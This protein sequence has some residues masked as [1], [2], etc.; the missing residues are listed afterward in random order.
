MLEHA[1]GGDGVEWFVA[2]VPVVLHPDLDLRAEPGFGHPVV[3]EG[4]LL[5]AQGHTDDL[6]AIVTSG[7]ERHGAPAAA[8]VENARLGPFMEPE[9][10]AHMVELGLLRFL[11]CA[12]GGLEPSARIG[13]GGTEHQA[14]EGIADVV[15]M[16][17]DF[18]IPM[19]GVSSTMGGSLFGRRRERRTYDTESARRGPRQEGEAGDR[20]GA[21]VGRGRLVQACEDLMD[22][23]LELKVSHHEGPG[24]PQLSGGPQDPTH[25]VG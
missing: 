4:C 14:I 9:L 5:S 2:D 23:A 20:S 15:V 22:I 3:S 7:M 16:A 12:G 13:H 25:R 18:R 10:A 19:P 21:N 24:E 6:R 17:D 1:D 11:E 8:D